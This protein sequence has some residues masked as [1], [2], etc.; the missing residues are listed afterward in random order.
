[1]TTLFKAAVFR[2]GRTKVVIA[3]EEAKWV[4]WFRLEKVWGSAEEIT[5]YFQAG[6]SLVLF[7]PARKMCRGL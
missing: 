4:L 5:R 7:W 2:L 6:P 3:A 1:M